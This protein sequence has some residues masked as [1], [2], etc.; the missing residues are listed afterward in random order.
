[1]AA[2]SESRDDTARSTHVLAADGELFVSGG[3]TE[4]ELV[5]TAE[6]WRLSRA[7]LRIAWKQGNPPVLP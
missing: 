4:N 7:D 5:R 3:R 2:I 6:G 1:M